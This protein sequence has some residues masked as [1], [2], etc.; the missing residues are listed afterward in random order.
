M[1]SMKKFLFLSVWHPAWRISIQDQRERRGAAS[2]CQSLGRTSSGCRRDP[3]PPAAPDSLPV[4]D[5]APAPSKADT[6]PPLTDSLFVRNVFFTCRISNH[7]F[8]KHKKGEQ[9]SGFSTLNMNVLEC[10]FDSC[11]NNSLRGRVWGLSVLRASN[12]ENSMAMAV[13]SPSV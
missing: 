9:N 5:P 8:K 4:A 3:L 2:S 10:L 12:P 11:G 1:S 6:F 13:S 7:Y